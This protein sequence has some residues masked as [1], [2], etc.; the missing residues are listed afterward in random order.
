MDSVPTN[1]FGFVEPAII[2]SI[3]DVVILVVTK[4]FRLV[5]ASTTEV[6]V[7]LAVSTNAFGF[8]T[9][10]TIELVVVLAVSTNAFGLVIEVPVDSS[11][12]EGGVGLEIEV[13]IVS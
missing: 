13:E 1:A 4:A 11:V 9:P 7:V 2:G 8:V 10:T 5:V 12:V 6:I 3:V